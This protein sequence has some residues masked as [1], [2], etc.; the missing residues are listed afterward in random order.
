MLLK[1]AYKTEEKKTETLMSR[2]KKMTKSIAV[3][4]LMMKMVSTLVKQVKRSR[5]KITQ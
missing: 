3:R 4:S 5:R 1:R 2:M